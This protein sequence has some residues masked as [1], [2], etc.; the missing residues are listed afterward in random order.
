VQYAVGHYQGRWQRY[1]ELTRS[2]G[3]RRF[4]AATA[5]YFS[6][7]KLQ[8]LHI[9]LSRFYLGLRHT[10]FWRNNPDHEAGLPHHQA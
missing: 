10:S 1:A 6:H 7:F 5:D 2:Y 9:T 4:P 3:R 8:Q